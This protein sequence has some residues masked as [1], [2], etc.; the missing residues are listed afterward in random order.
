MV[1]VYWEDTLTASMSRRLVA[2][3][4]LGLVVLG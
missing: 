2:V 4:P 3:P 1:T